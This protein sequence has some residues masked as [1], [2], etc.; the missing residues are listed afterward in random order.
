MVVAVTINYL[1]VLVS[2]VA[3][4]IV[5]SLW[6]GPI[7]GKIWISLSGFTKAD[8]EAAKKKGMGK[9]YF[10]A[11]IFSLITA[12]VLAHFVDYLEATTI[13]LGF[14]AAFWIWLGFIVPVQSGMFLWEGKSFKLYFLNIAYHIVNL[15]VMSAILVS[16]V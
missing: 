11:F 16:W 8:M 15:F 14:I 2:A 4:M 3:S 13:T 10:L 6:Y 9:T 1:A 7:F 12:Y 5:G